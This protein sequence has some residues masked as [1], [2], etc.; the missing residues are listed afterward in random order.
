MRF[1]LSKTSS[2][3]REVSPEPRAEKMSKE[4][5]R[6]DGSTHTLE[7]HEIDIDNLEDLMAF[8]KRVDTDLVLS[9]EGIYNEKVPSIEIYDDY[10]E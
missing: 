1:E 9:Q 10:R 6:H 2:W 5:R 8:M 4:E 3:H 7:W